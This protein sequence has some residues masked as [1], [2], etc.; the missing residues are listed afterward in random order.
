MKNT[1][2]VVAKPV[3]VPI[4][5]RAICGSDRPLRRI[6]ATR[7]TKSWTAPASTAPTTSQRNPGRN[8]NSTASPAQTMEAIPVT[9]GCY[10][11]ARKAVKE[12]LGTNAN[13]VL[14]QS[15][16]HRVNAAIIQMRLNLPSPRRQRLRAE[17]EDVLAARAVIPEEITGIRATTGN[18]I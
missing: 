1:A 12:G 2:I 18:T 10:Q 15:D 8:P 16:H 6:D 4:S 17:I 14:L 7:M 11:E 5:S 3:T 9:K 13:S